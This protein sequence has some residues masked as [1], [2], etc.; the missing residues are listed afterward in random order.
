VQALAPLP[1]QMRTLRRDVLVD[2]VKVQEGKSDIAALKEKVD[3][4][5]DS[6]AQVQQAVGT[7][8]GQVAAVQEQIGELRHDIAYTRWH[9]QEV[10]QGVMARLEAMQVRM[11]AA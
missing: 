8:Q 6:L 2:S 5:L 9:G 1:S 4:M 7:T 3:H 11:D 10:E